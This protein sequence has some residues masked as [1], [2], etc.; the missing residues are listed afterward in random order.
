MFFYYRQ[1]IANLNL[2]ILYIIR[3][4]WKEYVSIFSEFFVNV[5]GACALYVHRICPRT[6][7]HKNYILYV[8]SYFNGPSI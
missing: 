3:V 1:S 6:H 4:G 2:K 7:F 8:T 5:V